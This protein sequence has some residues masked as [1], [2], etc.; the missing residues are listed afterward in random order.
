MTSRSSCTSS[1]PSARVDY[2][3]GQ[4]AHAEAL[5]LMRD[6]RWDVPGAGPVPLL[7]QPEGVDCRVAADALAGAR[8]SPRHE[9]PMGSGRRRRGR[10]RRPG[11]CVGWPAAGGR[12]DV[13]DT[14][15]R[16]GRAGCAGCAR[17]LY[18][19]RRRSRRHRL[20]RSA[21]P[22][23]TRTRHRRGGRDGGTADWRRRPGG[24]DM[25]AR[26]SV[27]P[28][29]TGRWRDRR[30][31]SRRRHRRRLRGNHSAAGRWHRQA[32]RRRAMAWSPR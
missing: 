15:D 20:R 7:T 27:R 8:S 28:A 11:R 23:A 6:T 1:T 19:R 9:A 5:A 29:R 25:D 18:G 22:L 32:D 3:V 31:V 16:S 14:S 21:V 13:A 12:T 10:R 4:P 30:A 26:R 2:L 17:R 24:R